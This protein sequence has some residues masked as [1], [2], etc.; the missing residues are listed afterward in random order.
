MAALSACLEAFLL[1]IQV[2][3]EREFGFLSLLFLARK[4]L[5]LLELLFVQGMKGGITSHRLHLFFDDQ[6]L[7][8][9]WLLCGIRGDEGWISDNVCIRHASDRCRTVHLF[10]HLG[11]LFVNCWLERASFRKFLISLLLDLG[12]ISLL[13]GESQV[14]RF[15]TVSLI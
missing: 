3:F 4:N 12:D 1:L 10:D 8:Q 13:S 11:T 2:R 9:L 15:G 5:Y 7:V 14:D 6:I